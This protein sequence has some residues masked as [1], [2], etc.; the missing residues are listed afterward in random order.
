MTPDFSGFI[1]AALA[2]ADMT[3]TAFAAAVGRST[4][5]VSNI[6]KQDQSSKTQFK[7]PLEDMPKWAEALKLEAHQAAELVELAELCHA[8]PALRARYLA[9][10]QGA[11]VSAPLTV[12][13]SIPKAGAGDLAKARAANALLVER[14][15]EVEDRLA[16]AEAELAAHRQ[17]QAA[18][19][20]L[21]AKPT[22]END[23]AWEPDTT[24]LSARRVADA[25]SET[26]TADGPYSTGT[27]RP[28]P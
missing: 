25:P 11:P 16:K 18:L 13:A 12:P 2:Q 10:Q 3:L 4:G 6:L 21:L 19:A 8:P 22:A 23:L 5:N 26:R 20:A 28:S 7:P 17:E 15:A 27:T 9:L 1:K 24:G 14:L